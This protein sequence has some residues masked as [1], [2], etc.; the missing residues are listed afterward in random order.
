LG[1]TVCILLASGSVFAETN[2]PAVRNL[3][4]EDCI[5]I[6]LHHNLD[7]QIKRYNPEIAGYALDGLYGNYEPAFYLSAEHDYNQQP[8]GF[9]A[10]GRPFT[11]SKIESDAFSSGFEGTLPWGTIYNI[12]ITL[13]DQTTTRPPVLGTPTTSIITNQFFDP[14]ANNTVTYLSTNF[15]SGTIPGIS[16]EV[17]SGR[18]GILQLRQPLLKNFLLDN[19]R[20]QLILD[21]KNLQISELDVRSQVMTTVT[22]VEQAYYNLIYDQ[23]NIK[24]QRKAVE[25]AE[26]QLTENRKRVE[27]GAMAPLD[28]KQ[29]QSVFA[30]SQA[31]LLAAEGTEETAQRLLK[32]LLS[33]NY[34]DWGNV[35]IQPTG[36]LIAVPERFDL[37]ESWRRGLSERPDLLQQK[38]SLEKQGYIVKFQRNQLLPSLDLV[39]TAGYNAS[40]QTFG[41]YLD[42]LGGLD[43]PFYSVGGQLSFPLT[44]TSARNNYKSAKAT[45]EQ[46]SLTLKQLEQNVMIQIENAIAVAN[47]AFQRVSATR[48]ARVYAEAALAAEQKKLE[49]GKSTSFVVLQLTRDLTTARSAEIRALADYNIA[50]AQIA[51]NEGSTLE[52]R[53]VNIQWR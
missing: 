34:H 13:A 32:A 18:A 39:G 50:V 15:S 20:L 49:S 22:S 10:Q 33:D 28:E 36:S 6:A 16:G 24:V 21:R 14:V 27:V 11:G 9:D 44:Q 42:Q 23:E 8:G 17:F 53:H 31:D 48:E 30:S 2:A 47:T 19:T 12:G 4:L 46:I 29:A 51:L 5:E 40:A 35:E 1:L 52:R 38:I 43:N 37:Q 26:R 3:S 7:V 25:L 41:G 45:R